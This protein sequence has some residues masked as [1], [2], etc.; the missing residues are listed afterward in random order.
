M[1]ILYED[2][3]LLVVEKPVN[4]P[5][6]AD[7][8]GDADLLTLLKGYI[9]EKYHKPGD[10]YLGL[11]H[12]LDRPVGGVMVFARTS[13]AASRL[14]GQFA[15]D[16]AKKHY[17]ALLTG[18]GRSGELSD[19]IFR[20]ETTG[21][22]AVVQEGTPGAKSARLSY[23]AV[24]CR[25]G[26]TLVDVTLFTGRHHQIRV[27]FAHAGL[28]LWG[29][30]R[31]NPQARPGQQI[32]LFAYAL[33][34][35]HPTTRE[36]MTFTLLPGG[37]AWKA[38][39]PELR[40][41]VHGV[42]LVYQDDR[43][44]VVSKPAGISVAAA[45]GDEDTLESRLNLLCGPVYPVHRL[46]FFTTGLTMFARD[47]QAAAALTEALRKRTIKKFYRCIL[48]SVPDP[49]QAQLTAYCFKDPERAL[50]TVLDY[51]VPGALDMQTAYRVLQRRE[52]TCLAEV[53]LLTGRTHQIRAHMAHIGCPVLGD[54]KYGDRVLNR[55]MKCREPRLC[56]VRLEFAF[57]KG[58][59][60][61]YLNG[62]V[63]EIDPPF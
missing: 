47:P 57:P 59:C 52:E 34:F 27:Q 54:D 19:F 31:Y 24:A 55:A 10:V 50:L 14:S 36:P 17:F 56:A 6:Q 40:G 1:N 58:S 60:L 63:L 46:D 22:S 7:A 23:R 12:R 2:N 25:D 21:N 43:V 37:G 53:E 35:E 49:P 13:K 61:S 11:V 29:D 5:V 9:K 15:G 41:V 30:Q 48:K 20:D 62:K 18:Q 39:A 42:D 8:S 44:L 45:D 33:S 28:P 3:H 51:P 32:A 38:F 16:G 4:I 26:L